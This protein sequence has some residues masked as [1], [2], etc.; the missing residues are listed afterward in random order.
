MKLSEIKYL[1]QPFEVISSPVKRFGMLQLLPGQSASGYG[2]KIATD[3]MVRLP[4]RNVAYRVY[5][6]CFSNAASHY[7]IV[8]KQKLYL[9]GSDLV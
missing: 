5:A 6:V 2:S 3:R 9:K 4:G 7:V 1:E 8:N